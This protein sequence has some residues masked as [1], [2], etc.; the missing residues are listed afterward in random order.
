[1]RGDGGSS[2]CQR[3]ITLC[4]LPSPVHRRMRSEPERIAAVVVPHL[5]GTDPHRTGDPREH[6]AASG[7]GQGGGRD[8]ADL[9]P[10]NVVGQQLPFGR[11]SVVGLVKR[12]GFGGNHP[13]GHENL[14]DPAA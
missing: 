8:A 11:R 1:M 5:F 12:P 7:S 9:E 13:L 2:L 14:G 6:R 4:V 3:N 10:G